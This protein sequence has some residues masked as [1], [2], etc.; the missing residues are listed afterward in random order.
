MA[1]AAKKVSEAVKPTKRELIVRD[2]NDAVFISTR[3][4]EG[5]NCKR[6][7][8]NLESPVYWFKVYFKGHSETFVGIPYSVIQPEK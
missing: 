3:Y 2:C 4:I 6:F 1:K 5:E 8:Y 7:E